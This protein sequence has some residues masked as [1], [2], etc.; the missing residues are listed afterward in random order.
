MVWVEAWR[1]TPGAIS[2]ISR[3]I[4]RSWRM[5]ASGP[6]ATIFSRVRWASSSSLEKTSVLNVTNP[7]T[8]RRWRKREEVGELFKGEVGGAGPGVPLL[9]AEVDRVGAVLDG[10]ADAVHVARGS[11]HLG[12]G[13]RG[14]GRRGPRRRS[15]LHRGILGR[16]S[17]AR[18]TGNFSVFSASAI[19]PGYRFRRQVDNSCVER[20]RERSGRSSRRRPARRPLGVQGPGRGQDRRRRR[21]PRIVPRVLAGARGRNCSSSS[22]GRAESHPL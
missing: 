16:I 22:T 2:R 7:F 10:R 6:A 19:F 5:K 4:P 1:G 18:K 8:P 20:K 3:A 15:G 17:R 13:T 9:D 12:S 21:D 11:E 14:H